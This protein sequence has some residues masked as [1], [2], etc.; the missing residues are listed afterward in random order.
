[1]S[2]E[3]NIAALTGAVHRH[4]TRRSS[5]YGLIARGYA[6][7][8]CSANGCTA[9][10]GVVA[11]WFSCSSPTAY[12]QLLA[13][14][15]AL[16]DFFFRLPQLLSKYLLPRLGCAEWIGLQHESRTFAPGSY[17]VPTKKTTNRAVGILLC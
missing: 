13:S 16:K 14:N 5:V 7:H 6:P 2:E 3:K 15:F 9:A 1:M 8:R 4:C 12:L 10:A 17:F 11:H